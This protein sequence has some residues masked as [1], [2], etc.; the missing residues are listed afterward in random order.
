VIKP[1]IGVRGDVP[2]TASVMR[3][4]HGRNEGVV[5]GEG[6][7]PYF[8]DLDAH[9]MAQACV[10]EGVRRVLCAGARWD[11]LAA[12]DNFCWPDPVRSDRTPDGEHKLAQLVRCCQGLYEAC[13]AYGLPLI[14]GKDSMKNDALLE[15]VKISIPPTLL[16]SVMGQMQQVSAALTLQPR[17]PGDV[18]WVLGATRAELGASEVMRAA[19]WLAA[20]VPRTDVA[21]HAERYQAFVELRDA[22]HVR[23]AHVA[24]RGGLALALAHMVLAAE[25]GVAID[26]DTIGDGLHPFE[27][28]FA[29]TTG[30][31]V[32]TTASGDASHVERMVGEHGLRRLGAVTAEPTLTVSRAGRAMVVVPV[33]ALRTRFAA[34]L[35]GC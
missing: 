5:L 15:G 27:A 14:S 3:V 1:L 23:S 30:R 34:G 32:F 20:E 8:S 29:E 12:L 33:D 28:L 21:V 6:I 26:V 7:H 4:R 24:G 31:I 17:T 25:L 2:A 10:D 35:A 18:L 11:R 16:V 9:A 19:G 13:I 22:G